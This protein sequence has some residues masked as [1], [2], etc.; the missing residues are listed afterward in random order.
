MRSHR[1]SPAYFLTLTLMVF[2]LAG[3]QLVHAQSKDPLECGDGTQ[4]TLNPAQPSI[5][6]PGLDTA[7]QRRLVLAPP[8]PS[9]TVI[10]SLRQS[11]IVLAPFPQQRW[12]FVPPLQHL[13]VPDS[14]TQFLQGL[15]LSPQSW[16]VGPLTTPDFTLTDQQQISTVD[17]LA[18]INDT[19][20]IAFFTVDLNEIKTADSH[21]YT[22]CTMDGRTIYKGSDPGALCITMNKEIEGQGIRLIQIEPTGQ[23]TPKNQDVL[24]STLAIKQRPINPNIPVILSSPGARLTESV[25][26]TE[27]TPKKGLFKRILKIGRGGETGSLTF[28][29]AVKERLNYFVDMVRSRMHSDLKYMSV[30][31][32]IRKARAD[33]QKTYPGTDIS[34]EFR[35]EA[36]AS[37]W[38]RIPPRQRLRELWMNS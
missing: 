28:Y 37:H 13:A 35:S 7:R 20:S 36:G 21:L 34:V 27:R 15:D 17:P 16:S 32:V 31:D 2:V 4:T 33:F 19:S 3:E 18:P 22:L 29:N 5:E 23:D 24:R 6:R 10:D 38:V 25:P 9:Q 26:K 8:P 14:P 11:Q 1:F 12:D 30:E